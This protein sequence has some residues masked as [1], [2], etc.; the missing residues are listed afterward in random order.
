MAGV[1]KYPFKA[2][3]G[4]ARLLRREMTDAERKLWS[5]LRLNGI[6]GHSF[7]RQ[8]P[9]GNYIVDFACHKARLI[10]EVDGGQHDPTMP[11]ELSRTAFLK[12]EG[13]RILRFWNNEV[14][15]NLEG[16]YAIIVNALTK[17]LPLDGGGLGGGD[18]AASP[19]TH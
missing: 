3:T 9:L 17:A 8:V 13:Y 16:V 7:R 1:K 18:A 10:I 19:E 12:E 5:V 4:R 2:A 11:D 14:L 6:E 15:E